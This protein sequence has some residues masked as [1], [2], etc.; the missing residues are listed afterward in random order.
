MFFFP[1][2]A[3]SHLYP[4][5]PHWTASRHAGGR[6]HCSGMA[7]AG[8]LPA[9]VNTICPS[10]GS[11]PHSPLDFPTLFFAIT[12]GRE[13]HLHC[14][15]EPLWESIPQTKEVTSELLYLEWTFS[16]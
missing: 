1:P 16:K 4:V 3:V 7:A 15:T 12:E 11:Y 6:A 8:S 9:H 5:A 10:S 13:A 2:G 14:Q